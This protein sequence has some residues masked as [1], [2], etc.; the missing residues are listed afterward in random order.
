MRPL[1]G[2]QLDLCNSQVHGPPDLPTQPGRE[3]GRGR[4]GGQG[5]LTKDTCS[6]EARGAGRTGQGPIVGARAHKQPWWQ[7]TVRELWGNTWS[8]GCVPSPDWLL[9]LLTGGLGWRRGGVSKSH[10][11]M[12]NGNWEGEQ[13]PLTYEE[14]GHGFPHQKNLSKKETQDERKDQRSPSPF[15]S[16]NK[17]VMDV[18]LH[19]PDPPSELGHSSLPL[20]AT[21]ITAESL[22]WNCPGLKG[23]ALLKVTAPSWGQLPFSV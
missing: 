20:S 18:V 21:G 3:A 22:P 16:R 1:W 9:P 14:D 17:F 7:P 11:E 13:S 4:A 5:Q 2:L 19:L 15:L 12:G 6:K 10:L 8:G 23:S